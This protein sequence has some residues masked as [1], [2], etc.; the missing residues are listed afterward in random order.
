MDTNIFLGESVGQN[1]W[2]KVNIK[3]VLNTNYK[4]ISFARNKETHFLGLI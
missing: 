3:I 1:A 2:C 4:K